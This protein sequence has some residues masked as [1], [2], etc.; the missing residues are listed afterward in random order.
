MAVLTQEDKNKIM[1]DRVNGMT[2][3]QLAR[4][5]HVSSTTIHRVIHSSDEM[6]E[7]LKQ[8]K[9]ANERDILEYMDTKKADV[10]SLID[11]YL[12]ALTDEEKMQKA[13]L[14]QI[15]TALGIVLD[16]FA[17]KGRIEQADHVVGDDPITQSLKEGL[18]NG[19][20]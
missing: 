13:T 17:L 3:S 4:K 20:F 16:K 2:I 10:C 15:A 12:P 19:T 8:K 18:N 9:A 1:A 7:L 11:V 5:Y 14:V 6:E